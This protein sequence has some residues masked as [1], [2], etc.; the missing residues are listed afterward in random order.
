MSQETGIVTALF[1]ASMGPPAAAAETEGDALWRDFLGRL[2]AATGA[3][4]AL[5]RAAWTGGP[6]REWRIGPPWEEPGE[7]AAARMRSG[8][9]YSGDDLPGAETPAGTLRALHW[10]IGR[11]GHALLALHRNA[12]EF[13][14]IDGLQLSNLAPYLDTALGGWRQLCR[15]RAA[16]ARDRQLCRDLGAGWI[17]FAPSGQVAAMAEGLEA[18]LETAAGIGLRADGR[19]ALDATAAQALHQAQAALL[20]RPGAPAQR[21]LLSQEPHVELVL[22]T[23]RTGGESGLLGRLRHG[24][25]VRALPPERL[26]QAFGLSRS[27]ARLAACLAD[28]LDLAAAAAD[29]GWTTGTARSCSKQLYARLGTNSQSSTASRIR[30]S[31]IWLE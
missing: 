11:D 29:L 3:A 30:G 27:E 26:A 28:G 20:S 18:Q 17:L 8:R 12:G 22:A 9:V 10:R 6:P 4:S 13:R 21:V 23:D 14:A 2:A 25:S 5:L 16:A 15:G 1:A 31:A 24:Q 19:L 7:A